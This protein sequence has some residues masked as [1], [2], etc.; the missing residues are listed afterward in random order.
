MDWNISIAA[1]VS[2]ATLP[3]WVMQQIAK[4]EFFASESICLDFKRE[5]YGEE[6]HELA[7]AVKDIASFHNA[8]GGFI[9]FGVQEVQ[10]DMKFKAVGLST[11]PFDMQALKGKFDSW[12]K[13]DINVSYSEFEVRDSLKIGVLVIPKRGEDSPNSFKRRGP[14]SG[15]GKFYFDAEDVAVRRGDKSTLAKTTADWQLVLGPR[16]LDEVAKELGQIL[17]KRQSALLIDHNLPSRSFICAKFIGRFELMASLWAWL[18]DEFQYA[19][20]IAGEGGKGKTSLAY[21]FVT[22]VA[23]YA[24]LGITRLVWMT[25]KKKQFSGIENIWNQTSETHFESYRTLIEAIGVS[26]A[27]LVEEVASASDAE[28]RLMILEQLN[29][30]PTLFVLDDI[31]SLT[32]DDQRKALEFAQRHGSKTVRF[33]LTTR[34]NAS[35]SS[36]A[37]ITLGGLKG[38]EYKDFVDLVSEKYS[39]SLK[40]SDVSLLEN[41]TDGSPL[42]TDSIMRVARRGSSLRKAI[43]EWKGQSGE[44]AR[45]AVLGREISQLSREAKRSLLCLAF[46][47]QCSK[48]ELISASGLLD[49]QLGDALEE[50]QSLFIVSAPKIIESEPRFEINKNTALLA[51]SKRSDLAGDHVAIEKSIRLARSKARQTGQALN[52]Q[53]GKAISQA[54]AQIKTANLEAAHET[55]DVALKRQKNHPDLLLFKARL[56]VKSPH[57]QFVEARKYLTQAHEGGCEKPIIFDL[58]YECERGLLSGHGLIEVANLALKKV[59]AESPLWI[60]RRAEGHVLN[61]LIRIRN[62]E[63]DQAYAELSSAAKD[64]VLAKSKSNDGEEDRVTELMFGVHDQLLSLVP[65]LSPHLRSELPSLMRELTDRGD[66]RSP[67]ILI[68]VEALRARHDELSK[69][70]QKA[71]R[72]EQFVKNVQYTI[73]ILK[74][75]RAD[76]RQLSKDLNRM[77]E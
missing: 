36:S 74:Y 19:K 2:T 59:Q 30:Q 67:V 54:L 21:E 26:L 65:E 17:A 12:L 13:S 14:E 44:D 43:D 45:N 56:L 70:K 61:G 16:R 49:V 4:E 51:V 8:F 75:A 25:A 50:L 40:D 66:F 72:E 15:K 55:I 57:V 29:T 60:E 41:A 20:V 1:A 23:Q 53:V 68:L 52:S 11:S 32:P 48:S 10:K 22:Q 3:D 33:L 77:L 38:S 58:W 69:K 47:G 28:L 9:I 76:I 63:I 27:Y 5:G 73:D 34:S 71:S 46:L 39:V 37:A 42:L 35:Y 24:P 64:L 31:D 7:E 6:P 18:N 62:K